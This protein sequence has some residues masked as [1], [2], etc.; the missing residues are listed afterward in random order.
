MKGVNTSDIYITHIA[1]DAQWWTGLSLVN[2]TSAAKVLTITFND[3]RIRQITLNA[4]EHRAFDIASLFNNQPQPDIQ[5]AVIAN[6]SGVIGLELF[7]DI[8][9][10]DGILLTDKTASTLYYPHVEGNGWWTGIVAY[11]PS[12]SD[13]T[14]TITPYTSQGISLGALTPP[15][16]A[17]KGKYIGV[18]SDFGL[19][20][21]R[22]GSR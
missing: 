2:T 12:E 19:P 10:L 13:C 15:P 3:G 7:G 6:A 5:S 18:A 22:H 14:I 1:S 9:Q 21:G 17:G 8:N 16:I 20:L 4:N 11:N